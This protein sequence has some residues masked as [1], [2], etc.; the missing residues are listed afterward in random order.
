MGGEKSHPYWLLIRA[1]SCKKI[2]T[3]RHSAA[4]VIYICKKDLVTLQKIFEYI[5]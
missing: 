5:R 4:K 3:I 2:I 1:T